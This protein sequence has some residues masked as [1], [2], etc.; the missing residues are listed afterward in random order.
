MN[1]K[2]EEEEDLMRI[3]PIVYTFQCVS[4]IVETSGGGRGVRER[5]SERERVQE[6]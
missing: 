3:L 2:R 4:I 1:S 6:R 5:E